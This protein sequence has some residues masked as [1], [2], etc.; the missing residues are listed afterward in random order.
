MH[1]PE[2]TGEILKGYLRNED[3]FRRGQTLI[4]IPLRMDDVEALYAVQ[5][6]LRR[7]ISQRGIV[8]EVNPSS[9]LLIGDLLD[10]RNHPIL[11]L[12]PPVHEPN[13]PPPVA[14]AVG[15]DDPLTFS[16]GLLHGYTLLHK[17]ACAAGHPERVVH[18]WLD[19]IRRTGMDARFTLAWR[20]SANSKIKDLIKAMSDYLHEPKSNF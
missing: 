16:T 18:E 15:S 19:L 2:R 5:H 4:D 12:N 6:A 17:A 1:F 14:I 13:A 10:L 3:V 8:V 11:R 20:P 9:N 7:G